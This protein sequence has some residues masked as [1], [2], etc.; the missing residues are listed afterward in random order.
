MPQSRKQS[1]RNA[2]WG[3]P[4]K[5]NNV[6]RKGAPAAPGVPARVVS[7]EVARD[8]RVLV[9]H[10]RTIIQRSNPHLTMVEINYLLAQ[11]LGIIK[12]K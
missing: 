5:R 4:V 1:N 11:Q 10:M 7:K 9:N 8:A 6:K 2:K 12:R 3:A